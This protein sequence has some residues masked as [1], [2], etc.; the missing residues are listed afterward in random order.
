MFF[1]YVRIRQFVSISLIQM[2]FVSERNIPVNLSLRFCASRPAT[3]AEGAES[4][5]PSG[6]G[7]SGRYPYSMMRVSRDVFISTSGITVH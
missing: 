3:V 1:F 7:L 6:I 2:E 4:R 5:V